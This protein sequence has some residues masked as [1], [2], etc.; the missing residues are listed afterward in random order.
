MTDVELAYTSA[1]EQA[2]LLR[3]RRVSSVELVELYLRRIDEWNPLLGHYLT[4]VGERALDEARAADKLLADA[5]DDAPAFCGVPSSIK[6]LVDTAGVRTTQGTATFVDRVP[7]RDAEVVRR[8]RAAGFVILGKTNTPEFGMATVTEP[9]AYAPARN[10]WDPERTTGG[11]SGGAA[12]AVAA[13]LCPVAHASDGGGSIRVPASLCGDVGLKPAR[14]RITN[15]PEPQHRFST[16]GPIA[17]TVADAAAFLD[18]MAGPGVG[19]AFFAPPPARLFA[20]EVGA[21]PGRLRIA[22]TDV[23]FI[24]DA[25]TRPTQRRV[26]DE[27][28]ALLAD[29]G[30]ETDE[31]RPEWDPALTTGVATLFAAEQAARPDLPP[32]ETLD[33]WTRLLVESAGVLTAVDLARTERELALVCRTAVSFFERFDV[34]VTPTLPVSAP[35]IG[36]FK[37]MSDETE[38][39]MRYKAMASFTSPW[40]LTGQPAITLPLATDDDGLPVGV[41]LVGRPA[42]EATLV[43]LA[44]QLETARPWTDRRPP[45][46]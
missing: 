33:P 11:S 46:G 1:V 12:G 42:D 44:S 31:H 6:D 30:H 24:E 36:E 10:P 21:A 27:T 37:T 40:N 19:D 13:G 9:P 28:V 3:E 43:R 35:R 5:P 2:T 22:W 39:V 7:E 41:Q 18:V 25:V 29:L 38:G 8:I 16:N 20:D 17:R 26:L 34:L 15:D 14:G 23:P 4:V 32:L 45:T